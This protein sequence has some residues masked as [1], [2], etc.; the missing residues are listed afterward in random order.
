MFIDYIFFAIFGAMIGSFL[1]VVITRLHNG[2]SIMWARSQCQSCQKTLAWFELIPLISFLVNK[3]VCRQC[4]TKISRQDFWIEVITAGL[5]GLIY[6]VLVQQFGMHNFIFNLYT[7]GQVNL[8]FLL[9]L[10]RDLLAAAGLIVIFFYD[11]NYYLILD[12]VTLPL[13]IIIFIFNLFIGDINI[14]MI[15][16]LWGAVAAGGFFLLQFLVSHG[17][18]I[19]GGDIR[20]G[21]LIGVLLGWPH[22]V[23]ALVISY[24]LGSIIG[25]GLIIFQKKNM[26]SQVP[27]GTFL[28][29]GALIALLW[30]LEI[31]DWYSNLL[32]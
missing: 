20:L 8:E 25:V 7:S 4:K 13:I 19:G 18:W 31:I 23:T 10:L 16:M 28:S 12:K 29:V 26:Q 6:Y 15:N 11:L 2:R 5:F 32:F 17:R 30:G 3:G 9:I 27:F 1:G 21:V 24:I 14:S 22:T